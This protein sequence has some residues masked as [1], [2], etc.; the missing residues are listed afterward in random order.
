MKAVVWHGTGDIRLDDVD[1]P[2]LQRPTDAIVRVTASAICGTDLHMVRGTMPG[3]RPGTVLGHEA[4]GVV[5]ELGSAVRGFSVGDR[6]VVCSTMSCGWCSYCRAGYTAQCD[7]AN[8][9]G[10]LAGTSFFGGPEATG[11]ID[12]LQ[13]ERVRVP[14]A[15][16]TLVRVPDGVSDDQAI[17]VSDIYPTAWF[18]AELAK[19]RDGDTVVVFG[20]GVVGQFAAASAKQEGAGRVMV[21]DGIASRLEVARRQNA[22]TIDFNA[23]DPVEAVLDLTGG[24]GADRVIDAVGVDA[25]TPSSGP[26]ADEAGQQSEMFASEVQQAAPD[27]APNGNLWRPGD[28]PSQALRW[29]VQAVAKAGTIGILGVYPPTFDGFPIGTVLNRNLTVQAGN[30]NHRRY[31][32]MLLD[33]VASGSFDPLNFITQTETPITA[34]D[35]YESFDRREE[36]WLKTVLAVG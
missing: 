9:G 18:G 21:V 29:A 35:A 30:C 12:G 25:Q 28:G 10:P 33:R 15:P 8:P 23:E 16:N 34:V 2:V 31:V 32:P 4:V 27:A 11:S 1:D 24:I 26:A 7:N 14:W 22:E 19:V 36:G 20:A 3:M 6:V 13:A 5:E 17:L